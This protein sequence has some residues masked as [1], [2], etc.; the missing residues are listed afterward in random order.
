MKKAT[1]H[2]EI[3]GMPL[4]LEVYDDGTVFIPGYDLSSDEALAELGFKPSAVLEMV[5]AFRMNPVF[6]VRKNG[7]LGRFFRDNDIQPVLTVSTG[8]ITKK[9]NET[10]HTW[11]A[12]NDKYE[13]SGLYYVTEPYGYRFF[14]YNDKSPREDVA[15]KRNKDGLS[16]SLVHALQ[17]A[18]ENGIYE[19]LFDADGTPLDGVAVHNW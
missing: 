8:H 7:I 14:L 10:L 17:I 9:D 18:W 5:S 13:A 12:V 2:M 15:E 4:D 3:D 6:F 19:V 11:G 1:F 16:D